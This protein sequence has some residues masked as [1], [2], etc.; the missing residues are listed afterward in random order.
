MMN[1]SNGS[2]AV[3][4]PVPDLEHDALPIPV[5]QQAGLMSGLVDD[6]QV[7]VPD[8]RQNSHPPQLGGDVPRDQQRSSSV[9]K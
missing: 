5:V 3:G 7:V 2:P 1:C 8:A 9:V 4:V 6:H